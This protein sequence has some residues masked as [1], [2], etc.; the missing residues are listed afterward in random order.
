M[1]QLLPRSFFARDTVE[2][3]RDLL[4]KKLVRVYNNKLIS[5][6]INE[7]E[8]YTSDDP[9]S[10]SYVGKTI[11]NSSMFGPVGH[12]Y[13]YLS[14]GI[15]YCLNIVSHTQPHQSGGVLIR[16]IVPVDGI[17]LMIQARK[18]T[19]HLSD[20][21]GKLAQALY[22]TKEFDGIDITKSNSLLYIQDAAPID[23]THILAMPRV[24]ITRATDVLR[25]FLIKL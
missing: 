4:G 14:Y 5:G 8:A 17:D 2:V 25:R 10:H 23:G 24:G 18:T 15:H 6:I 9:A 20:G 1:A 21:P 3:A 19:K 22:I 13:V 7:T 11:R 12:A 16:S